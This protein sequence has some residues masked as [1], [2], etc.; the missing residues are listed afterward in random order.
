MNEKEGETSAARFCKESGLSSQACSE[1]EQQQ[2][3]YLDSL[4]DVGEIMSMGLTIE[5]KHCL[6]ALH[7]GVVF[8]LGKES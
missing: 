3:D 7:R 4:A 1:V 5:I 6:V 8:H 2:R